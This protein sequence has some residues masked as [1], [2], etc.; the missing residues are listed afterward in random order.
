VRSLAQQYG[1]PTVARGDSQGICFLGRVNYDAFLRSHLGESSGEL[2]E[3][4]SG[5]LIGTHRGLWYHTIGQR[6]G[7]GPL[8]T[9]VHVARGPWY[10]AR[11]DVRANVLYATRDYAGDNRR[12]RFRAEA[13]SWV[14]GRP[15]TPSATPMRLRVKVRHG[16]HSHAA[17]VEVSAGGAEAD[18]RLASRDKGLAEGQFAAFY[19]GDVC[20][21]SG[22]ISDAA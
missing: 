1:L 19:D 17:E 16:A 20:L 6:R 21:G 22:V 8:L 7:L 3:L 18:V 15:P 13:I 14:A 4:E 5:E 12:D 11:K 2:R 10:V 9:D